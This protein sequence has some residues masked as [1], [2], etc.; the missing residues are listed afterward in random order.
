VIHHEK[1]HI[2]SAIDQ[3]DTIHL[4]IFLERIGRLLFG[5]GIFGGGRSMRSHQKIGDSEY[6]Q[7][8]GDR[9]RGDEPHRLA[10]A[11]FRGWP[12]C[13]LGLAHVC[14]D[15]GLIWRRGIGWRLILLR[16]GGRLGVL[17]LLL[18]RIRILRVWLPG[19]LVGALRLPVL[20]LSRGHVL[21]WGLRL[22]IL[23]RL[24]PV[25]LWR[26]RILRCA[27]LLRR[28]WRHLLLWGRLGRLILRRRRRSLCRS[29]FRGCRKA[30]RALRFRGGNFVATTRAD[31]AKHIYSP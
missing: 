12:G 31:P 27:R 22:P 23:G 6:G 2:A 10:F 19:H 18:G 5:G 21:R 1:L 16:L 4:N 9:E 26:R 3:A 7:K 8:T 13:G 29:A 20:R 14:H 28:R 11:F 17:W 24:L 15:R 25:L 30:E